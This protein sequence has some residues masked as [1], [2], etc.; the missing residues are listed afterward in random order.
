MAIEITDLPMKKMVIFDSYVKL[1]EGIAWYSN[2]LEFSGM[3]IPNCY[4]GHPTFD[5]GT[6]GTAK[7]HKK[8]YIVLS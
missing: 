3:T 5:H 4:D 1:P 7:L 2:I 6:H 8:P